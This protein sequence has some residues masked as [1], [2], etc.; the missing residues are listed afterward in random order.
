[1][2]T[3][4]MAVLSDVTSWLNLVQCSYQM[5][6]GLRRRWFLVGTDAIIVFLKSCVGK[7]IFYYKMLVFKPFSNLQVNYGPILKFV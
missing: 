5:V 1:M 2:S 4:N 3:R 6:A 7:T